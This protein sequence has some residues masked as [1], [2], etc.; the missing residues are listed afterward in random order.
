M[1]ENAN[2]RNDASEWIDSLSRAI[3]RIKLLRFG[4]DAANERLT[5]VAFNGANLFSGRNV[6]KLVKGSIGV[7]VFTD[8]D[9]TQDAKAFN[10]AN[11]ALIKDVEQTTLNQIEG[12]VLRNFQ[13]GRRA[14]FVAK[15][16]QGVFAT[17]NRRAN[18]IAQDQIQKLNGK[19]T[20]RRHANL[21]I[22]KYKWRT[23][24]DHRVRDAHKVREGKIFSW[25]N[26][27]YDGHPGEPVNCR[28]YAEPEFDENAKA[29]PLPTPPKKRTKKRQA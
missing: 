16:I 22:E 25:D 21:G 4:R 8:P 3:R 10:T 9:I 12:V 19:L 13:A 17:S 6:T 15:E 5:Q 1:F 11:V 27:P 24:L 18:L 28:C 26:P 20:E 2:Q 14:S 23:V 29:D 7:D